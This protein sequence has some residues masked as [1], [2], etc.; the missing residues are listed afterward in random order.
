MWTKRPP[1][2]RPGVRRAERLVARSVTWEGTRGAGELGLGK[3]HRSGG[4]R[5]LVDD[6][7]CGRC[8]GA[9]AARG[10][11]SGDTLW[12]ER[13]STVD[14][15]GGPVVAAGTSPRISF[16]H[17]VPSTSKARRA[18]A[19]K[20]TAP[21]G[22]SEAGRR[23]GALSALRWSHGAPHGETRRRSGTRFLGVRRLPHVS[24][25]HESERVKERGMIGLN[26]CS[27]RRFGPN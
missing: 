19:A 4:S 1:G 11:G 25:Y 14:R 9:P 17:F 24:G 3:A 18:S 22:R 8:G 5:A 15:P 10:A 20:T 7:H 23:G 16:R 6:R 13:K 26:A 2:L 21:T 12:S 27:E